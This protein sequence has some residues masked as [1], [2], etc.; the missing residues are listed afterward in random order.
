MTLPREK[1]GSH[2]KAIDTD[3]TLPLGIADAIDASI[4]GR[5]KEK[6]A[7]NNKV[8]FISRDVRLFLLVI[9]NGV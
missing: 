9:N 3:T 7:G 4:I 1:L 6:A 8:R 2:I 5:L